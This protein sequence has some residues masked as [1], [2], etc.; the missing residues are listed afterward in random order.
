MILRYTSFLL[1]I[2]VTGCASQAALTS[3]KQQELRA[4]THYELTFAHDDRIRR[5]NLYLPPNWNSQKKLPV[6]IMLHSGGGNAAMFEQRTGMTQKA[7]AEG[8]IVVYP[9]GTGYTNGRFYTWNS[10]HCCFYA[11]EK[12]VD[13]VGFIREL[14][15]SLVNRL[16]IDKQR[17][18]LAGFSN[19]GML[20]YRLGAAMP[21]V[22]A[23]IAPI[24]AT[25]GGKAGPDEAEFRIHAP[26]RTLPLIT[27]HGLADQ[28]ILYAGGQ[29]SKAFA[30]R[31]DISVENSL[32]YWMQDACEYE[33]ARVSK[34]T[35]STTRYQFTCD[36]TAVEL[37]TIAGMGHAWA[38]ETR[39]DW[40]VE[41]ALLDE[42]DMSVSATDIIWD[43]FKQHPRHPL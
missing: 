19:G 14:I 9:Q 2:A 22:I 12:Q 31:E 28:Q 4:A 30:E 35:Q 11:L 39:N 18:Y 3:I 37:Y 34:I 38:S 27:M 23:A 20:A 24:S 13:D 25:I 36:K 1:A 17:I 40:R 43:F 6:V 41:Y 21:D 42:P 26:T 5:Y 16:H 32:R 7:E 15:R 33:H 10:G 8:F 29:G